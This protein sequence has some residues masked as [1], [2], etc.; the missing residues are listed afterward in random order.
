M[1]AFFKKIFT[2][3][4]K[5]YQKRHK[6][7]LLLVVSLSLIFLGAL[8]A[9]MV[10]TD[11]NRVNI[12]TVSIPTQDG[13]WSTADIFKPKTA[14]KTN[15][16]PAIVVVPG[17]QRSKETQA[18]FSIELARRGYVVITIDPYAQ[19]DSSSSYQAASATREGYGAFAWIDYITLTDNLNYINKNKVG[20]TGHSAGGNA[21]VKAAAKYGQEV[22]DGLRTKSRL[23]SI[24][25]SG[26]IRG[27]SNDW[28]TV[29]SNVGVSYALYDEGAYQNKTNLALEAGTWEGNPDAIPADMRYAPESIELVN[30]GLKQNSES[31]IDEVEIGYYYG[32]PFNNTLRIINNEPI[33]HAIQP[34]DNLTT[35]NMIRFFDYV[36]EWES[37]GLAPESQVFMWR[38]LGTGMSL[39][40]G[41]LFILAFGS[42]LLDTKFFANLKHEIPEKTASQTTSDKI[43]FWI[44][45]AVGAF[46]AAA[47]YIPLS[48]VAQTNSLFVTAQTG[49]QTWKFPQRMT[50]AVML[51]AVV[52]GLIGLALFFLVYFLKNRKK[53]EN[54]DPLKMNYKEIFKTILLALIVFAGFFLLDM[55]VYVMFHTDFRFMFVTAKPI[56]NMRLVWVWLM[57]I[58]FFFIFYVSNSI[59][60][61]MSMRPKNWSEGFSKLVAVLGNSLGLVGVLAVQYI[62]YAATGVVYYRAEWL[63]VNILFG[64]LP[65]MIILPL[66]NRFFFNK[67]G[68]VYLGPLV[69]CMIFIM[70]TTLNTVV[71]YPI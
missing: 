17:F 26:Y 30:S 2:N 5:W 25:V 16:A 23:T 53:G 32:S 12:N 29:Y 37:N 15:P 35:G 14:T 20:A 3:I 44:V 1:K 55:M 45:F 33:L 69:T 54:L 31:L 61:N 65:I 68:K 70:M 22:A 57:Y 6:M 52:S 9:S 51:W 11:F 4:K 62:T 28:P 41:L 24:Y 39:V 27:L 40:G 10:Q 18:S 38:E 50:N 34:Y 64:L 7:R 48:K 59:R 58:P 42:L 47:L 56:L 71:Y 60:V 8:L 66:Y 13:Q 46:L 19:G 43:V 63:Y 67:T 49:I 36:F 21:V